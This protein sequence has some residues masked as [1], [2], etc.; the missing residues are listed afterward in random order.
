MRI[1]ILICL[2]AFF[3][4]SYNSYSQEVSKERTTTYTFEINK[5]KFPSQEQGIEN[6]LKSTPHLLDLDLDALNYKLYI[7]VKEG[8]DYG[9][10]N[11]ENVKKAV[12]QNNAEIV[13]FT[14]EVKAATK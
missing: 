5:L 12:L 4:T 3:M 1:H 14:K 13:K 9:Y 7:T 2:V 10:L 11:L 6:D 8:A